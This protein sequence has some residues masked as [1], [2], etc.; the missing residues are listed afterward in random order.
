VLQECSNI[1]LLK[2]S[3]FFEFG[4]SIFDWYLYK[5]TSEDLLHS[6]MLLQ[7]AYGQRTTLSF[8]QHFM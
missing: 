2:L 8:D 7:V 4:I 5:M 6:L 3:L 1:I